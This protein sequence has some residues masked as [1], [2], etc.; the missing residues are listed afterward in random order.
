MRWFLVPKTCCYH[1]DTSSEKGCCTNLHTSS[2]D[3]S[4]VIWAAANVSATT[5]MGF[6][7]RPGNRF[8]EIVFRSMGAPTWKSFSGNRFAPK[9]DS[10]LLEPHLINPHLRQTRKRSFSLQGMP[11]SFLCNVTTIPAK[12][13]DA[14]KCPTGVW[15]VWSFQ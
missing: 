1:V 2:T 12:L 3:S 5:K 13:P 15:S 11:R 7:G 8:P 9:Q 10:D 4:Q 6:Q 14:W